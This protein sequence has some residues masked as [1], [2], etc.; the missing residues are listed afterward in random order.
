MNIE[1]SYEPK[2][3]NLFLVKFPEEFKIN[4]WVVQ[5]VNRPKYADGKWEN[6]EITFV[7]PIAESTTKRLFDLIEIIE[8]RKINN[9]SPLFIFNILTC[10]STGIVVED[11]EIS[12]SDVIL[13]DFDNHDYSSDKLLKPRMVVDPKYCQLKI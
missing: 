11:W 3:E 9:V 12:V 1:K 6:I 7:D 13:I 4:S 5:K 10:D 2:R 8:K